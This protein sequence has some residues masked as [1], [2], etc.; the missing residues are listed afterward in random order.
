MLFKKVSFI[1]VVEAL[2]KAGIIEYLQNIYRCEFQFPEYVFF[3]F[4]LDDD[5]CSVGAEKSFCFIK[6]VTSELFAAFVK[7]KPDYDMIEMI[8]S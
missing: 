3:S 1:A 4:P 8:I 6:Y 7:N 5:K 2:E